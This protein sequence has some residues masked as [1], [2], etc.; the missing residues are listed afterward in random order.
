MRSKP[1]A[2]LFGRRLREA[3]QR[4]DIPQDKLGV[5]VGLD[6]TTASSRISRYET[7]VHFPKFETAENIA[8]ALGVLPAF[9]F[10]EDDD[11]AAVILAW[12]RLN[13]VARKRARLFLESGCKKLPPSAADS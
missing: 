3:R 2:S 10:C 9:F 12:P 13:K 5:I 7:G 8:K 4:A 11:L 6:E 1:P